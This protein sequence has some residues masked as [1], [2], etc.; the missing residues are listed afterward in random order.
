MAQVDIID[1]LS[2]DNVEYEAEED[3]GDEGVGV[4]SILIV[5]DVTETDEIQLLLASAACRVDGKEDWP[6]HATADKAD[7]HGNLEVSKQ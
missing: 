7:G 6:C 1:A 4:E 3:P 5:C 2:R